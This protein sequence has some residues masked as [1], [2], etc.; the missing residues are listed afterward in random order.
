MQAKKR[1]PKHVIRIVS[2]GAGLRKI[3]ARA[4]MD[5]INPFIEERA[6]LPLRKKVTLAEEKKYV[7]ESARALDSG[8]LLNIFL[9]ADGKVSGKCDIRKAAAQG[10]EGNVSFGLAVS[11]KFRGFGFGEL[12]LRKSIALAKKKFKPHKMWIDHA[13]GNKVAARLYRKVGFVQVARL[14]EYHLHYGKWRD[15]IMMEYRGK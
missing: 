6:Y 1:A 9:F 4:L 2:S 5:F 8:K 15:K 12:L 13:D 10:D 3:G 14:K 11:K 7:A